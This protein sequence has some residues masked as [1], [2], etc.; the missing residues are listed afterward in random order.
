MI[1][2]HFWINSFHKSLWKFKQKVFISW[3]FN[4]SVELRNATVMESSIKIRPIKIVVLWGMLPYGLVDRYQWFEGTCCPIYRVD[5]QLGD[6]LAHSKCWHLHG[7]DTAPRTSN[8]TF[9]LF[10]FFYFTSCIT[11]IWLMNCCYWQFYVF[12]ILFQWYF[13]SKNCIAVS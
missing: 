10:W 9:H 4:F 13:F 5:R 11:E 1:S 2:D 12:H 8:S 6:W 3:Y 7:L